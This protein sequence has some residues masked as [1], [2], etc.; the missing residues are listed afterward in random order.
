MPNS[1]KA[2]IAII[3]ALAAAVLVAVAAQWN[4][5]DLLRFVVFFALAMLASAMK[6]RLPGFKTTISPNFVFVLVGIAMFSFSETVLVGLG[7]ALVQ[8][9]W[10]AQTRP[11]PVQVFFNAACLTVCTAAAFAAPHYV[12]AM[13]RFNSLAAMMVLGAAV[14]VA[15]NTGLVSLVISLAEQRPMSELWSSCYEWTFPYF[16]V[17]A[18]VAGLASAASESTTWGAALLVL[19]AM[20]FV[21]R[22]YR[23]HIFR[24]VLATLSEVSQ[25]DDVAPVTA[26]HNR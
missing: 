16:L 7:G 21:Y 18:A 10:R 20:Y 11:K 3:A 26:S 2:Y 12:L 6:I 14:Y 23:L 8:T 19:P 1:A 17:G 15:L 25:Q 9:F 5:A 24:A 22:Y 4:P 13:L